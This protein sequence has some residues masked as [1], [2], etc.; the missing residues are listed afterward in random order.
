MDPGS[1]RRRDRYSSCGAL[2]ALLALALTLA[3]CSEPQPV[4][5]GF[6]GGLSGRVADLG[7]AGRNG[8]ILA[9]ED[10]NG[11]GGINGRPIE[12]LIRDDRQDA[13]VA[14]A[15]FRELVAGGV[16][17]VIGHMTSSMS[18]ATVPIAN[19]RGVLMVSPTTTTDTLAGIDDQFL[20]VI[21]PTRGYA[22]KNARYQ[23]EIL[24]RRRVAAI[25]DLRNEAY[26]K[27]WFD[28]FRAEFEALGGEVSEPLTFAS[29]PEVDFYALA[30]RLLEAA[31]EAVLILANSVDAALLCQQIRK[32][33]P[34]VGISLSEWAATE[35]L[36]ELGGTAVEGVLIAQFFDRASND[37]R[38]LDFRSRFVQRFS[39]EPGFAGVAGYDA[40]QVVLSARAQTDGAGGLKQRILAIGEFSGV[41]GPLR[42]DRFGD[43]D[44]RTYLTTVRNGNFTVIEER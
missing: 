37:P 36:V 2:C 34:Q 7:I 29:G 16:E 35:R 44:R 38:Y 13:E 30:Q 25:Y 41:Q 17:V 9:V 32:L 28:N 22:A 3:G 11:R 4:R 27:S 5:L 18:V 6:V 40:A 15:A 23:A 43:A 20:R 12:L 10:W 14:R 1:G 8:V 19:E 24:K 26:T 21:S 33:D 42:I 31:P 39:Q